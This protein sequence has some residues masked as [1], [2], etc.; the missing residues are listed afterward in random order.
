MYHL[1]DPSWHHIDPFQQT[2]YGVYIL[3]GASKIISGSVLVRVNGLPVIPPPTA[4]FYSGLV[5]H[6]GVGAPQMRWTMT[7]DDR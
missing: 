6:Q 2:K 4:V 1:N 3:G 7:E 5:I